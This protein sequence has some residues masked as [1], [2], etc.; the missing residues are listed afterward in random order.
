MPEFDRAGEMPEGAVV[1][2]PKPKVELSGLAAVDLTAPAPRVARYDEYTLDDERPGSGSGS[3]GS[4]A[5]SK[6]GSKSPTK[7]P[8]SVSPAPSPAPADVPA[9]QGQ[10]VKVTK[11]RKKKKRAV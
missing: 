3:A 9:E 11:V 5:R 4:K 6:E 7:S 10:A 1:P 8:L 2:Q